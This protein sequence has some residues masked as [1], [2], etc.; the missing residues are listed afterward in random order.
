M[1]D[2]LREIDQIKITRPQDPVRW[3]RNHAVA[4]AYRNGVP[5]S[6]IAVQ[7]GLRWTSQVYAI[8]RQLGVPR[9]RPHFSPSKS[10]TNRDDAILGRMLEGETHQS[11]ASDYGLTRERIRQIGARHGLRGRDTQDIRTAK[12]IL[13][14]NM[15]LDVQ[16][17]AK[18]REIHRK[19]KA[20]RRA[21]VDALKA[22]ARELRRT[23]THAELTARSGM[24][25]PQIALLFSSRY[26]KGSH[27]GRI[28]MK[29]LYHAAGLRNRPPGSNGHIFRFRRRKAAP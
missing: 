28:G 13:V 2:P 23:P 19:Q 27:Y 8:L 6:M 11:I 10:D 7:Y 4:E 18:R 16:A 15:Q 20:K 17:E 14:R 12:R 9:N 24:G 21:L 1:S 26:G 3:A 5:V 25:L 22:L 29:R